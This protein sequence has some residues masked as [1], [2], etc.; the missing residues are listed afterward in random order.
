MTEQ[1]KTGAVM[2]LDKQK[3]GY[4]EFNEFAEWWMARDLEADGQG[5]ANVFKG[6]AS[7]Q[8]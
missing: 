5:A 4:I 6:C 2:Q 3:S 8:V 7:V 1:E